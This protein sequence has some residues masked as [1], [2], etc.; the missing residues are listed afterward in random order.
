MTTGASIRKRILKQRGI[1][2]KKHTKKPI[3]I[4]DA[5]AVF[6][7]TTAM[8]LLEAKHN[9]PIDKLIAGGTIY[10]KARELDINPSTVYKWR[11]LIRTAKDKDWYE[12]FNINQLETIPSSH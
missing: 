1:V 8:K 11:E 12:Q 10:Q 9:K 3:S 5:P 6:H 7:K 2:L 4:A